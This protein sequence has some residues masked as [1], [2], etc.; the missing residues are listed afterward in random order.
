M[1]RGGRKTRRFYIYLTPEEYAEW[2]AHAKEHGL[3][4]SEWVRRR[5]RVGPGRFGRSRRPAEPRCEHGI[6]ESLPCRL[7]DAEL[8]RERAEVERIDAERR[9]A[10]ER[11]SQAGRLSREA[12]G[13]ATWFAGMTAK[14]RL[15]WQDLEVELLAA[16]R[17]H[18]EAEESW[19]RFTGQSPE[20]YERTP[21]NPT[22][23]GGDSRNPPGTGGDIRNRTGLPSGVFDGT[24]LKSHRTL[25]EDGMP[26]IT[27]G[28]MI[29]S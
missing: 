1:A 18:N 22:G 29:I 19:V 14:D 16:E 25:D 5:C 8:A 23:T 3:S 26:F 15:K 20:S 4:T 21:P 11:R 27:D 9:Q 7:C 2:E 10:T 24:P 6:V 17:L 28:G 13:V 12:G